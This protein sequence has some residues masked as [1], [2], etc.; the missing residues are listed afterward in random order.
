MTPCTLSAKAGGGGGLKP[1]ENPC[2]EGE[3]PTS[4]RC[5][6]LTAAMGKGGAKGADAVRF[7]ETAEANEAQFIEEC[8]LPKKGKKW[9]YTKKESCI[10]LTVER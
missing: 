6:K 8:T 1:G 9:C 4:D 2:V 10:V 3:P 7:Y 5:R